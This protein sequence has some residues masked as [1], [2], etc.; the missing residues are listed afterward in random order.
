MS[1]RLIPVCAGGALALLAMLGAVAAQAETTPAGWWWRT[2]DGGDHHTPAQFVAW[3]GR[4]MVVAW[5]LFIPIGILVAR[6]YKVTPR[7]R[8]PEQ[9]D[10]QFWW[11]AHQLMQYAGVALTLIAIYLVSGREAASHSPGAYAHAVAG[12]TLCG[13]A[14]IQVV[15]AWLRGSKGGPAN[16]NAW[17]NSPVVAGDHYDLTRRR[18]IFEHVH[19]ALGYTALAL[20][21]ATTLLG[22]YASAAPRWMW[23]VLLCWWVLMAFR[24][25]QLQRRNT[26]VRTYQAIWGPARSHPGNRT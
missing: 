5:S 12:W 14:L 21:A 19:I 8:F 23:A 1:R 3:H 15:G 10:N 2:I 4:L 24:Y 6:F 11:I 22:L 7:Q 18:I 26:H 16:V 17:P 25:L 9:L 13:C 20:A